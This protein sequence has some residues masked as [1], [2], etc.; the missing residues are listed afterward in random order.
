MTD[1]NKMYYTRYYVVSY[2][3]MIIEYWIGKDEEESDRI[4]ICGTTPL[5]FLEGLRNTTKGVRQDRQ[6]L[7]RNLKPKVPE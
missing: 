6:S 2:D 4:I 1:L 3:G 7:G 5:I